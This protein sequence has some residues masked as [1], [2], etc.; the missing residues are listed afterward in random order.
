MPGC[1]DVWWPVSLCWG[2]GQVELP[3]VASFLG[4]FCGRSSYQWPVGEPFLI[5][6]KPKG[7]GVYGGMLVVGRAEREGS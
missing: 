4:C 3:E 7:P 5:I 6:Q 2:Q 1:T